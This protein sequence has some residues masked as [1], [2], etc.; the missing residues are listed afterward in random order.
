[1]SEVRVYRPRDPATEASVV[2]EFQ[3]AQAAALQRAYSAAAD[4]PAIR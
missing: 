1:V 3:A 2:K 4:L